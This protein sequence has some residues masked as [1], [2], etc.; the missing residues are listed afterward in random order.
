[1]SEKPKGN[2]IL[3]GVPIHVFKWAIILFSSIAFVTLG[4]AF[5]TFFIG[6]KLDARFG[7]HPWLTLVLGLIGMVAIL[8]LTLFIALKSAREIRNIMNS[9]KK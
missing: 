3:K 5:G 9:R 4:I 2:S 6:Q 1:M 7:T 8:S